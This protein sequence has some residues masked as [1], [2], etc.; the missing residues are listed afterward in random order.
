MLMTPD[1][2][3]NHPETDRIIRQALTEDIGSGDYSSLSTIPP[4]LRAKAKCLIKENGILAGVAIAQKIFHA[5]DPQLEME[6]ILK[7]GD[8]I[9]F[10][11]YCFLCKW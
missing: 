8:Q 4:G 11:R 3:L 6:F 2:F 7:D 5:V 10:W 9:V 1:E